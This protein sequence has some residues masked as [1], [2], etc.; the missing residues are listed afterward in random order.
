[1]A[2]WLRALDPALTSRAVHASRQLAAAERRVLDAVA[3]AMT[4]YLQTATTAVLGPGYRVPG[5]LVADADDGV[6]MPP[7]LDAWP[8][9]DVWIAAVNTHITPVTGMVFGEAF[10][11]QTRGTAWSDTAARESYL[12][13][14]YDRLSPRLWPARVFEEVRFELLEGMAAGESID[15]LRDRIGM[16]THIDAYSRVVRANINYQLAIRDNPAST[17]EQVADART[18]LRALYPTL[19]DTDTAW[20]WQARRVARTETLAA[21]NGGTWAG[22][23]ARTSETGQAMFKQWLATD[24]ARTRDTHAAADGQIQPLN[25]PFIVGGYP[26]QHPG[27]AGGPAG[28]VINCRCTTLYLDATEAA[29]AGYRVTDQPILTGVSP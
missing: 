16:V 13:E 25:V 11:A 6:S 24:D 10:A 17:P 29:Q 22:Q 18:R 1:M 5:S 20:H 23:V 3:A 8:P 21:V 27:E 26:L 4:A 28:E 2:D 19:D 7:D 9:D 15:R 12:A 14:V